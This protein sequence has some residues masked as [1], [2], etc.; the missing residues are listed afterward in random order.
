MYF[1]SKILIGAL[2]CAAVAGVVYY[3]LDPEKFADTA[4]NLKDKVGD[5]FNKAVKGLKKAIPDINEAMESTTVAN[6]QVGSRTHNSMH[7][8]L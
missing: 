1:M 6:R 8:V 5:S 7:E 2:V 4:N 3:I